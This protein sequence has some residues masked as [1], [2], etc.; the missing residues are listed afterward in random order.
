M[1]ICGACL[2]CC[3]C[4]LG[5]H[6]LSNKLQGEEGEIVEFALADGSLYKFQNPAPK[7]HA[8]FKAPI[9]KSARAH[10]KAVVWDDRAVGERSAG[11]RAVVAALEPAQKR[12]PL[13]GVAIGCDDRVAHDLERDRAHGALH[14]VGVSRTRW[15]RLQ[16][17][18]PARRQSVACAVS[19]VSAV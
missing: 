9:R 8:A 10:T 14:R 5:K 17:A 19:R 13:V 7:A 11:G 6:L 12:L 3:L 2:K 1:L 18:P 4:V 15:T 16:W